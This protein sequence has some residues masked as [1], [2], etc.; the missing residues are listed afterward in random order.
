[1]LIEKIIAA[2]T[3]EAICKLYK[4][5]ELGIHTQFIGEILDTLIDEN[6]LGV[7]GLPLLEKIKPFCYDSSDRRYYSVGEKLIKAYTTLKLNS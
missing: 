6:V 1:M 2:K 4:T 3:A 7:D 5:V